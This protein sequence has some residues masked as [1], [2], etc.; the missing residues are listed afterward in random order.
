MTPD[1]FQAL[2]TNQFKFRFFL[3]SR[4]PM[5]WVAGLRVTHFDE[6]RAD[7]TIPYK[8]WTKNPF[9]SMY[10]AAQSMAA[11]LSTGLFGFRYAQLSTQ[12]VSMLV[13]SVNSTYMKKATGLITFSC[14]DGQAI[15]ACVQKAIDTGEGQSIEMVSTGRDSAGDIVSE[16]AITWSF[17]A[18]S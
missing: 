5:A 3:I 9:R 8:Y 10:F 11:E 16:F 12:R 17:K 15:K 2:V 7:V 6:N 1:S 13:V 4:L 14:E 18:K